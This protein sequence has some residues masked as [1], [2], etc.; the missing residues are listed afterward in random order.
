LK[1][2]LTAAQ[3][4]GKEVENDHWTANVGRRQAEKNSERLHTF[5]YLSRATGRTFRIRKSKL[6]GNCIR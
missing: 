3:R 5:P 6:R 4:Q 2:G 1:C